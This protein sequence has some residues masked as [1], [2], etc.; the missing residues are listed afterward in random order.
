[1]HR[2]PSCVMCGCTN[3]YACDGGCAWA[4]LNL[5]DSHPTGEL[6]EE[7]GRLHRAPRLV[8]VG[9]GYRKLPH[10][11]PAVSLYTGPLYRAAMRYAGATGLPTAILSAKHGI[12]PLLRRVKPY[13]VNAH[14]LKGNARAR[15]VR[16]ILKQLS[17]L[18]ISAPRGGELIVLAAAAYSEPWRA[19]A[20][21]L[22]WGVSLPLEGM[23]MGARIRWL[24]R[25]AEELEANGGLLYEAPPHRQRR[26]RRAS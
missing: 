24:L 16:L 7:L 25:Q 23:G 13:D 2:G 18:R 26:A 8:L 14:S 6:G 15:W 4:A 3:Q 22:G 11:A 10:P 9:C 20:H 1:M 21:S 17:E 12:L 5:C 19:Q